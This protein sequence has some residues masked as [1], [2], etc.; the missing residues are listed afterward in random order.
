MMQK[1]CGVGGTVKDG[2]I[3]HQRHLRT[4]IP[5]VIYANGAASVNAIDSADTFGVQEI[6]QAAAILAANNIAKIAD[7]NLPGAGYYHG[8]SC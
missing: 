7:P 4:G 5:E 8:F 1:V 3:D 6:R 2:C